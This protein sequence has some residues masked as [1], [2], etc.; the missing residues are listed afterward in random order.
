MAPYFT[1]TI[2]IVLL[3]HVNFVCKIGMNNAVIQLILLIFFA[4]H[5]FND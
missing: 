3:K 5:W 2:I 1:E 4:T